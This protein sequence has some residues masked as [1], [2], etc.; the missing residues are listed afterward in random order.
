MTTQAARAV[1]G[2]PIGI[3]IK[4]TIGVG[5]AL[6]FSS[7]PENY[8][9]AT[10]QKLYDLSRPW[11]FDHNPFLIRGSGDAR[12]TKTV[13]LWNYGPRRYDFP[14]LREKHQAD[15]YL[16]NAEIWAGVLGVPAVLN[17]PRLYRYE[18]FEFHR[19]Q[20]ILLHIDGRSH[21][22]MP[23]HVIEHVLA[24]YAGCNLR[25]IGKSNV[26]LGIPK[27]ETATLWD[28]AQEIS[29]ASMLIG[30]DSGPSWIA[31]CYPDVVVKKLRTKPMPEHF[32]SW[33]PLERAN[34]HSHWDDRCHQIFNP[35]DEDI[36]FTSSY[37]RI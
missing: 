26:D 20:T 8:Y 34:I 6:Q 12:V 29:R 37:R 30:M 5:D 31:A 9:R 35:T 33:V 27:V 15:V 23:D 28:L 2:Q 17:R 10:G 21:G 7:L 36:G 19:R 16:S 1:S 13:E 3:T 24:K 4:P 22:Q 14:Q 18:D 25:Q 11:F 32:K